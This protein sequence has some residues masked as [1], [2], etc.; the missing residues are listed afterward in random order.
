MGWAVV[1][2][3]S[4]GPAPRG[5]LGCHPLGSD[6]DTVGVP[7]PR[8]CPFV[9]ALLPSVSGISPHICSNSTLGSWLCPP[10]SQQSSLKPFPAAGHPLP[11]GLV[12]QVFKAT[13]PSPRRKLQRPTGQARPSGL[14]QVRRVGPAWPP[15]HPQSQALQVQHSPFLTR[16]EG[17]PDER[18]VV[19]ALPTSPHTQL[20]QYY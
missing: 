9:S 7:T 11:Q 18:G 19:R 12:N 13:D 4:R 17:N 10:T 16:G 14:S 15:C 5:L 8:L 2:L 6:V 3:D 20:L 1:A